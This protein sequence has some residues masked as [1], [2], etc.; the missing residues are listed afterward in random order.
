MARWASLDNRRLVPAM[1]L[2]V[3]RMTKTASYRMR[4]SAGFMLLFALGKR[5]R[6][7]GLGQERQRILPHGLSRSG[8]AGD[9]KGN[10]FA[11]PGVP[12]SAT[13]PPQADRVLLLDGVRDH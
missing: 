5:R 11:S 3:N 10:A 8:P 13:H 1:L 4:R 9:S 12:G 2:A 7:D 6:Q